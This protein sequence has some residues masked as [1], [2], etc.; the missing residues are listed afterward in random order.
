MKSNFSMQKHFCNHLSPIGLQEWSEPEATSDKTM[1]ADEKINKEELERKHDDHNNCKMCIGNN[2]NDDE[3]NT[4]KNKE[5]DD[6]K[7]MRLQSMT[8]L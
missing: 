2:D 5:N 8:V 1:E 6:A 3:I 7:P 4:G